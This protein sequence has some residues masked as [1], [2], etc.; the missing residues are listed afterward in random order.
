MATESWVG[1]IAE[2]L[3]RLRGA[4]AAAARAAGRDPGGIRLIAVSKTMPPERIREAQAA[5]QR[6]FGEN[7]AQ[8]LLAKS[9]ALADLDIAWHFIGRLQSNK[10]RAVAAAATLIHSVDRLD[11][12][13]RLDALWAGGPPRPV[14]VQVNTSGEAS[15][16]GVEP[17]GLTELLDG[18]AGLPHL[19]VEGLMT[20]GPWTDDRDAVRAAFRSLARALAEQRR[21]DRPRAPLSEL[22][23]GM[24]GD[25]EIAIQEGATLLRIGTALFG[26]RD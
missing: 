17:G 21:H 16:S 4:I 24:S 3:E 6:L 26:A 13:H 2:N 20:I 5:G 10:A 22:S 25:F 12:A 18:I 8:E 14:L 11:L 23:M 7:R 19:S 15:K 1:T 9:P